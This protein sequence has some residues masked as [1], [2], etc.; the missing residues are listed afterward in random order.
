MKRLNFAEI[1]DASFPSQLCVS[2]YLPP[3][4]DVSSS[5]ERDAQLNSV[6]NEVKTLSSQSA[7]KIEERLMADLRKNVDQVRSLQ[8]EHGVAWFMSEKTSGYVPASWNQAPFAVVSDTFHVK[9]LFKDIQKKRPYYVLAMSAKGIKL[10]GLW[11]NGL[12]LVEF[13]Q[14]RGAAKEGGENFRGSHR[15]HKAKLKSSQ[16]DLANRLILRHLNQSKDPL[17]VAGAGGTVASLRAELRYPFV[18]DQS[19]SCN[20]DTIGLEELYEKAKVVA[21]A[22]FEDVEEAILEEYRYCHKSKKSLSDI[23]QIVEA[24]IAGRIEHLIIA[25]DHQI[26][27]VLDRQTGAIQ[28]HAQQKNSRDDDV[29]DDLSELV[30]RHKGSVWVMPQKKL[31]KELVYATLRW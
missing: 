23:K 19:V 25:E 21:E 17:L 31:G 3:F 30:Y 24:A 14:P 20:P 1:I 26:W 2:I 10:F 15:N 11:Q 22:H 7:L 5:K 9:P 27:G 13:L 6:L 12:R 16:I 28:Y 29:L 4:K 18:L 8:N